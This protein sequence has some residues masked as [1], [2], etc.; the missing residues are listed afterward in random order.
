MS[1]EQK[2]PENPGL[3]QRRMRGIRSAAKK[4]LLGRL[5][6]DRLVLVHVDARRPGVKVPRQFATSH[7]LLLKLSRRFANTN[8]VLD[9]R[10]VSATLRFSSDPFRCVLPWSSI[11]EFV[12]PETSL[13][14]LWEA[15]LPVELGGPPVLPEPETDPRVPRLV[16]ADASARS[17]EQ[18]E[19]VR[20]EEEVT[21]VPPSRSDETPKPKV[22]WLQIVR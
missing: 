7:D 5:L 18:T 17:E 2:P 14:C 13:H 4:D 21:E 16:S 6:A 20:T 8:M 22:P 3:E 9:E 11:W 1:D 19:P 15:D 10:G 12:E